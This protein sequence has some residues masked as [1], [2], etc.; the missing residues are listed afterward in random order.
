MMGE[1]LD[2]EGRDATLPPETF[3]GKPYDDHADYNGRTVLTEGQPHGSTEFGSSQKFLLPLDD[4]MANYVILL[5]CQN[6]NADVRS[7]VKGLQAVR[8]PLRGG[9]LPA[10]VLRGHAVSIGRSNH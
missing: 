5:L 2:R 10:Q 3:G 8:T 9:R 7:K 4:G 6:P 1:R